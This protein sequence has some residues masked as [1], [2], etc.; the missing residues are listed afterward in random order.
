[1]SEETNPTISFEGVTYEIADLSVEAQNLVQA[2]KICE[3]K[4]NEHQVHVGLL[5]EAH[6]SLA[7]KL[8]AELPVQEEAAEDE[9]AV[10]K[11]PF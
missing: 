6:N 3:G 1:M 10:A 5:T 4:I 7:E 8:K 2:L 9:E 11:L